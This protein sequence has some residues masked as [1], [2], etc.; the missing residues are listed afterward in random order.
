MTALADAPSAV[1]VDKE[2]ARQAW[3]GQNPIG[4]RVRGSPERPWSEVVG[5][6]E[7]IR[8]ESLESDQRWR[9][10]WNYLQRA[11]DRMTLVVRTSGDAHVLPTDP[12][13]FVSVPVLLICAA[14]LAC[15]LP[16]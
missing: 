1:V 2:V 7:L 12:V 6:V 9:I 13:T 14:L 5:V 3:P 10:Y 4:K 16:A 8:H 15:W 11:R